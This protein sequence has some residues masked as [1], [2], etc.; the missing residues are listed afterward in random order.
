[1]PTAGCV[2]AASHG[3]RS[4][5]NMKE[6]LMMFSGFT[7]LCDVYACDSSIVEFPCSPPP[8]PPPPPPPCLLCLLCSMRNVQGC[9]TITAAAA[10]QQRACGA[11]G[12]MPTMCIACKSQEKKVFLTGTRPPLPQRSLC[13]ALFRN[14]DE[15]QNPGLGTTKTNIHVAARSAATLLGRA[16]GGGK[17]T[18]NPSMSRFRSSGGALS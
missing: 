12:S 6:R 3:Y 7:R 5:A 16:R 9:A 10:A 1:M 18:T 8:P 17:N 13:A 4:R 15:M 14:T 11:R 2:A